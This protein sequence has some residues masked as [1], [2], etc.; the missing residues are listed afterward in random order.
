MRILLTVH[1]FFPQFATGTEVLTCSVALELIARGHEVHVLTGYPDDNDMQDEERFDE[2]DYKGIHVY[3][4]HH[5][6]IPMADHSSMVELTYDNRLATA[7][8]A[9][10]VER[11]KPD[12]VHFFHLSRLGTG[13]I[14][15]AAQ[16]RI[17]AF[18]TPTDFWA[19]CITGQLVF[20]RWQQV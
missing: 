13:L 15:H 7:Y 4:F 6:F 14:A 19:V 16:A 9:R 2:Y 8:F 20:V 17:P 1:Q 3:R 11:F 10:I 12:V 18:M 5:A